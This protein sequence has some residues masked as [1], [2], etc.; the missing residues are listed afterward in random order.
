MLKSDHS[1]LC[2]AVARNVRRESRKKQQ[3]NF[4]KGKSNNVTV[5]MFFSHRTGE[6]KL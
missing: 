6:L 2:N 4:M 5:T 1:L 3:G